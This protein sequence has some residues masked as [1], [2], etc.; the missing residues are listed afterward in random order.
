MT[1][2]AYKMVGS[3]ALV[4]A[5][6]A[7]PPQTCQAIIRAFVQ[8]KSGARKASSS[9]TMQT[10]TRYHYASRCG[11]SAPK[12]LT[13]RACENVGPAVGTPLRGDDARTRDPTG[14]RFDFRAD[15]QG[16][17]ECRSR[18]WCAAPG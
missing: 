8:A 4:L 2:G 11:R 1:T 12:A 17:R 5:D 14:L 7:S 15:L 3:T 9:G 18:R 13:Y 16:V 10:Q 6:P